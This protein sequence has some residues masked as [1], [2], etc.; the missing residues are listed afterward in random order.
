MNRIMGVVSKVPLWVRTVVASVVII[1]VAVV[2]DRFVQDYIYKNVYTVIKD[3]FSNVFQID[4]VET[5]GGELV[6][7]GWVF[8]LGKDADKG[9]FDIVL[10]DYNNDRE[11]YLDT[12]DV[13][14]NDVNEYFL[15]EY[16]YSNSG[17]VAT[18]ELKEV[19][20]YEEN[21]EILLRVRDSQVAYGT[22]VYVSDGEISYVIPEEYEKLD[23]KGTELEVIVNDGVL[24]L[25]KPEFGIYIYQYENR[26][27]WIADKS[28][29]FD[30]SGNT[31]MQYQTW[32]T[33]MDN[34][35]KYRIEQGVLF[36]E[37]GFY[38]E[39]K[40]TMHVGNYRVAVSEI[41]INYSITK[42]ETG[43]YVDGWVYLQYIR[44]FYVFN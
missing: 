13:V 29:V 23:V 44:P 22:R 43:Y 27:Y 36:D 26:L 16:D 32:T 38:F 12:E 8:E 17:F 3:D 19:K 35:P 6:L 2:I 39:Q 33:Q 20:T 40:E 4:S 37:L 7:T 25:Y 30:I 28:F 18:C 11:Y 42:I 9:D 10:Y 15:C 31:Y 1:C 34:L 41:P 21:Y 24:R 14:R 5:N